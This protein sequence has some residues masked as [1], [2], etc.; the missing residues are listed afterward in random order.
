MKI[1]LLF[2]FLVFF[3]GL[4]KAQLLPY[5]YIGLED[6]SLERMLYIDSN[7]HTSIKPYMISFQ[8]WKN[9]DSSRAV[10]QNTKNITFLK[11]IIQL[12]YNQGFNQFYQLG[13]EGNTIIGKKI[14][15][16]LSLSRL[17]LTPN[18]D[19]KKL[20]DSIGMLPHYGKVNINKNIWQRTY[21]EGSLIWQ[22]LPYLSFKTGIGNHFLG[23]GHRSLF[24]SGNASP[25]PFFQGIAKIWKVEYFILYSFLNE[26]NWK[27]FSQ[28][29]ERKNSTLHYLSWNINKRLT[30]N[31]FETVIWQVHDSIGNRGFDVNYINPIIF[32]RPIE[33]SIGSPDNV[34]MGIGF[35]YRIFKNTHVYSQ[36]L[37]DEF[38]LAEIK[39]KKGWWG[40]KFGIQAGIKTYRLFGSDKWFALL[41]YNTVRPFTYSH[42]DYLS[43]WGHMHQALA[44]PLGA[45]FIEW[46]AQSSYTLK[47]MTFAFQFI[48]QRQGQSN[49][50]FNAG[51]NIYL[52]YNLH[53]QEYGNYLL[54]GSNDE[55]KNLELRLYY[56]VK[57]SWH[58]R[59]FAQ[60]GLINETLSN[61]V[62]PT[63]FYFQFGL[64]QKLKDE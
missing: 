64:L 36:L 61:L 13:I 37:L 8:V 24:L 51:N 31:A 45:N 16:Q 17:M 7:Y 59:A 53:R 30:F 19:I 5:N 22:A 47:K 62:L 10:V 52:S 40:N 58:L 46:V 15:A 39:A 9:I 11:P 25:Y 6:K 27:N 38:K 32:F 23:D 54:I 29:Y 55:S 14:S 60:I 26:P 50:Q 42:S 2:I 12:N 48:Y 28:P 56:L 63:S 4:I 43:N 57:K 18:Y 41:E 34:I 21:F 49:A 20:Y 44:H 1:N 3:T 33:F 35:R